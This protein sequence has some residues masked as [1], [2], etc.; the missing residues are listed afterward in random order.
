MRSRREAATYRESPA[1]SQ[2]LLLRPATSYSPMEVELGMQVVVAELYVVVGALVGLHAR[3]Q[4][5]SV[6]G[7]AAAI[8]STAAAAAG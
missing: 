5:E 8:V 6:A 7:V 3:T 2:Q 1:T 4:R